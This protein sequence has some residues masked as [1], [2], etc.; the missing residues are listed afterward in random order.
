[1]TR[2]IKYLFLIFCSTCFLYVKARAQNILSAKDAVAVAIKNNYDLQL[3]RN[4]STSYAI[5]KSFAKAAFLPKIN[6]SG[7]LLFNNNNQKQTFNDG[8]LRQSKGVRSNALSGSLFLN[9]VVFDGFKMFATRDKLSEYVRLGELNI[10]N[11][12]LNTTSAVLK[13]YY[14]IVYEKQQLIAIE[15]QIA[16]DKERKEVAEKKLKVGLGAKPEL[17]QAK[18]DLNAQEAAKL[19]QRNNISNLK[20]QLNQ[21]INVAI[22]TQYEVEDSIS[23]DDEIILGEIMTASQ[24]FNPQLLSIKKNIDIGRLTLKER[25][26]EKYPVVSINSA[27]NYNRNNNQTV[28]NPFSPLTSL[29]RGFNYGLGVSIPIFNN[30]TVKRDIL[31]AKLDLEYLDITYRKQQSEIELAISNSFKTY[32]LQRQ[33]LALEEEN[34]IDAKENVFISLQ[35]FRNGLGIYLELREAQKSLA[36][37]YRRL[38]AARYN[39][40]LAEIDLQ[41]LRGEVVDL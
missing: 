36:D 25:Q 28:V 39:T 12:V 31:Q 23:N 41:T 13:T 6:A 7:G 5:D 17:L 30:Y 16:I 2:Q 24:N 37:G 26:A 34:I 32:Q 9:W 27:Y 19:Q 22:D 18:V 11:Q 4:D 29:N 38:F 10:K 15:E 33:I 35:R 20:E 1:M 21:I 40:K 14:N 8:T 3:V